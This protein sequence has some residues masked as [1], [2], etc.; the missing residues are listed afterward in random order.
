SCLSA[1][2]SLGGSDRARGLAKTGAG[3]V[4]AGVGA[5]RRGAEGWRE[6][7]R[8]GIRESVV[9]ALVDAF[10]EAAVTQAIIAPFIDE[11]TRILHRQGR[12]AALGFLEA[13]LNSI[14]SAAEVAAAGIVRIFDRYFDDIEDPTRGVDP[15]SPGTFELPDATVSVLAAPQWALELTTAAGTISLA[16]E[17]MLEAATMMQ[18]T[19]QA[20]ITVNNQSTRGIDAQRA[21]V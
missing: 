18:A 8:S 19:F 7:L 15:F 17:A 3:A 14:L 11:F 20:G 6:Q 13:N 21:A 9:G 1:G 16:G 5:G 10:I 2:P 12:G 4:R